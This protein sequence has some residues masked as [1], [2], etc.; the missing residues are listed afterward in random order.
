[1]TLNIFLTPEETKGMLMHLW[2]QNVKHIIKRS[3]EDENEY[4]FYLAR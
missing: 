2:L 1:M 4:R 3:L